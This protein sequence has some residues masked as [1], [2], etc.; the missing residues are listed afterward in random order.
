MIYETDSDQFVFKS[1]EIREMLEGV[2]L[3]EPEILLWIKEYIN[4]GI[5]RAKEG[6]R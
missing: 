4:E 1:S 3:L 2:S 5:M 6:M